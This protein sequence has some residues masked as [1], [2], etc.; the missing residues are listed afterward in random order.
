MALAAAPPEK[1]LTLPAGEN[2]LVGTLIAANLAAG[3]GLALVLGRRLGGIAGAARRP[4][5]YALL[6]VGVYFLECVAFAAGMATQVFTM[7]LAVVWGVTFGR[8]LGRAGAPASQV[9]RASVPLGI[10]TSLPTVT[11]AIILLVAMWLSGAALTSV[12]QGIA[13]GI[14][15]F[16]P[17]P[18]STILG[19][20]LALGG[21]TLV[22]KTAVTAGLAGFVA[23]G[24][25]AGRPVAG[26]EGS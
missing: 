18:L 11:F 19:F 17:W 7:S 10:Y 26:K 21:G 5:R 12:E 15:G 4:A 8:R 25:E 23:R 9:F 2:V 16:V 20:C 6:L 24:S 14:P 13:L 3:I 1:G 22:A